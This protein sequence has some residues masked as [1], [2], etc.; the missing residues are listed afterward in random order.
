MVLKG[1]L[2]VLVTAALMAVMIMVAGAMPAF[3]QKGLGP[4]GCSELQGL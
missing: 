3:A 2:A 4:S 1:R